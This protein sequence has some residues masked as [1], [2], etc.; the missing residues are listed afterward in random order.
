MIGVRFWRDVIIY[1]KSGSV[2]NITVGAVLLR[3]TLL[4]Y[5]STLRP[6]N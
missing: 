4:P 2:R 1:Y 3:A 6:V 5:A